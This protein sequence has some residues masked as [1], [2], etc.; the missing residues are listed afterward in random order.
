M[1]LHPEGARVVLVEP[2][3]HARW[4]NLHRPIVRE[5]RFTVLLWCSAS[6]VD[7]LKRDAPD[8]MDWI[9]HRIE[10]PAMAPRYVV[11]ELR[12]S[13]REGGVLGVSRA[14]LVPTGWR[15]VSAL[16][17]FGELRDAC[18]QAP[19]WVTDVH[20]ALGWL[21][22]RVA[23][24]AAGERHGLV[25]ADP[26]VLGADERWLDARPVP[27]REA[28]R[29]LEAQGVA[30]P[31]VRAALMGLDP[32][33][34][35]VE[36]P[37]PIRLTMDPR[38]VVLMERAREAPDVELIRLA[39]ELE[40]VSL[41]EAWLTEAAVTPSIAAEALRIR[42]QR[43][44]RSGDSEGALRLLS[45]A[46]VGAQGDERE[47][48]ECLHD[49]AIVL[50]VRGELS[51]AMRILQAQ[52][53]VYE[54]LGDIRSRAVTM[55]QIADI[56]S[57]W[58]QLDEALR[59]F[60]AE[61]LPAFER[62]G[63]LR[64]R[65]V[66][67]G[68]IAGI[69][70]ARGQV[71]E[72]L[73]VFEAEVLPGPSSGSAT[74][75]PGRS[76]WGRSP[77]SSRRGAN[78]TTPSASARRKNSPSTSGSATF[79][80]GGHPSREDRRHPRGARPTRRRPPHLCGRS[81]S[82][83][84]AA[85]RRSLRAVTMGKIA[86]ILQARG[87]LDDALRIR[88]RK[89]SPST[90]GSATFARGRSP[91]GRS[92]TS[93]RRADN[94]TTPS[95]SDRRKNSPSTSGSATFAPGRSPWGRSPTSSRRAGQLD[96]ALR[97]RRRKNSPS[98]S[99]SATFAPERAVTMGKIAD[100]L[101][102]RGQLD[103]ALRIRQ[104]EE[105]PVFERLGEVGE[106]AVTVGKI[107]DILTARGYLDDALRI[108]REEELPV[109]EQLGDEHS[110]AVTMGKIADILQAQGKVDEALRTRTEEQLP[111]YER[112][113]DVRSLLVAHVKVALTLLLRR[114][115]E[116]VPEIARQLGESLSAARAH[117]FAV[118]AGQIAEIMEQLGLPLPAEQ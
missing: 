2:G 63:A 115:A 88:G 97:I 12:A 64:S 77:T 67:M 75:A 114:R 103:D 34:L 45:E 60:E 57:A 116:D 118:E 22:A 51:E 100:I 17:P 117:G 5:R 19:V 93:S 56:L 39:A 3:T 78:S 61:V 58:G 10:V 9:S 91:W 68:Q 8:F 94:S 38:W 47:R 44:L 41:A 28:A 85:R 92:P 11:E 107:A 71:D 112:L 55:G 46:I 95:A 62:L 6:C 74:F 1:L 14:P 82:C 32:R 52:L 54:R 105:L 13:E 90:S 102:A 16:A 23:Q 50:V 80:P 24:V 65:A 7:S 86:D 96:D 87:Q 43:A 106:Q 101:T 35:G 49:L 18:R 76:P 30:E 36:R 70:Q 113:G 83:L 84:R 110:R 40:L 26:R 21:G 79:A 81:P 69:L 31:G 27:W 66:T 59:I 4:L 72:A 15:V 29:Q 37:E 99:G 25:L 109:F 98:T 108:R 53:P 42:A 20:D 111:V 33:A 48:A 73:R 104:E 89:N